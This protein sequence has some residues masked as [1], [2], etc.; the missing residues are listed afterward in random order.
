M[1]R[2]QAGG[3]AT[4]SFADVGHSTD[5]R[6]MADGMLI[7]ELHPVSFRAELHVAHGHL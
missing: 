2:E 4:E 7:G 1:L 5:A 6:E 3:D